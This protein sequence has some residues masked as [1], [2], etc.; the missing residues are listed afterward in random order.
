M[1]ILACA[2]KREC[3]SALA[4]FHYQLD[5]WPGPVLVGKQELLACIVGVGPIAAALTIGMLLEKYPKTTGIINL[6]I[7]G[8]YDI[9]KTP[10]ASPCIASAE[11]FPE[12][13]IRVVQSEL[14]EPLRHQ[15]LAD[16]PLSP[17]NHL[18]LTPLLAAQNMNLNLP[19]HWAMGHSLTVS[20]ISGDLDRAAILGSRY[21]AITENMEG[22]ALA[23]AAKR[24]NIPFLQIRTVSNLAGI[25]DKSQWKIRQALA[26]LGKILPILISS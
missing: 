9:K 2:T 8:A 20:G 14:E 13:G 23:L 3:Q 11:T 16:L 25:Q 24:Y 12:Y 7:C 1:I 26:D 10:M 4:A 22:F 5:R 15:M 18:D 19:D 17:P 6:G 21:N